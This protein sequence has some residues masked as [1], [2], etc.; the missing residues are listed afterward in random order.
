MYVISFG[1]KLLRHKILWPY[2]AET[3]K[4][5]RRIKEGDSTIQ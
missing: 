3:P 5:R 2:Q 1:K 4:P